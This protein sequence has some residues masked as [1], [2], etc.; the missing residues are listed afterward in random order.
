MLQP[1][2]KNRV[3]KKASEIIIN[4][5]NN[6]SNKVQFSTVLSLVDWGVDLRSNEKIG[7]GGRKSK[8]IYI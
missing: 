3:R 2:P 7:E 5:Y 8:L 6:K 4:N 1:Q